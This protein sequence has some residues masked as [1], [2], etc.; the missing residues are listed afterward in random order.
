MENKAEFSASYW[1]LG[2]IRAF[3]IY[4][5]KSRTHYLNSYDKEALSGMLSQTE[6]RKMKVNLYLSEILLCGGALT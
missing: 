1:R 4:F 5:N 6:M 2:E 3:D